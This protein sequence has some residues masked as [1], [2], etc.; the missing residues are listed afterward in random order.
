M[1]KIS[2]GYPELI[3]VKKWHV[4]SSSDPSK[5]YLVEKMID[6]SLRCDCISYL[7]HQRN[8]GFECKHCRRI[9]SIIKGEED[10]RQEKLL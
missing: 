5:L 10:K 9:R 2:D 1:V 4:R 8:K 3:V 6:G 7:M